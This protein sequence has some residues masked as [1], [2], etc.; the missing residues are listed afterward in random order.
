MKLYR[1]SIDYVGYGREEILVIAP[2][3][4]RAIELA[5]KEFEQEYGLKSKNARGDLE[6]DYMCDI[7]NGEWVSNIYD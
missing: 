5:L 2:N 7:N 6:V 1:L 3:E 4:K